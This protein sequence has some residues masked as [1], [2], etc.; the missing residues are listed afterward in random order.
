MTTA[1]T[2]TVSDSRDK[3]QFLKGFYRKI[4]LWFWLAAALLLGAVLVTAS[5]TVAPKDSTPTREALYAD[6]AKNAGLIRRHMLAGHSV[7]EALDAVESREGFPDQVSLVL[8]S[9]EGSWISYRQNPDY[10]MLKVARDMLKQSQ[11]EVANISNLVVVGPCRISV[12]DSEWQLL[13]LWQSKVLLWSRLYYIV[14]THPILIVMALLA[15]AFLCFLLVASVISP[16]RILQRRVRQLAVG[17]LQARIPEYLTHRKDEVGELC[18]DFNGMAERLEV[19][20]QTKQRL[21]RDVSHELRSPLTRMQ[22]ALV[23][24]RSKAG[25]LAVNEHERMERDIGRLNDMIGQILQWSRMIT[26][27]SDKSRESFSLDRAVRE[28]VD[29]ADFEAAV[30]EKS[31]VLMRCDHCVFYGD[32]EWLISAI[33]NIVRN[34]I[35]FSPKDGRVELRMRSMADEVIVDIRDFGPG[36]PDDAISHLFEPFYRVDETRG[37]DNSGTGLGMAIAKAAVD[38]HKG[39]IQAENANP[40]LRI[41]IHLPISLPEENNSP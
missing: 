25:D 30:C 40:G 37:G 19:M 10:P 18:R 28:L 15:S 39:T 3:L 22:L 2:G 12:S 33:E 41:S 16:L 36:V 20:D 21:L 27:A 31:V 14:S 13:M 4:L 29:N 7:T 23:L 35:R 9:S 11:P 5:V 38:G 6:L 8:V 26:A 32:R 17:N 34:A 1:Q 24:A